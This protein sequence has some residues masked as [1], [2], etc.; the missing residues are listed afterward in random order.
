MID[1]V[2]KLNAGK[3]RRS[4]RRSKKR[5]RIS[6]RAAHLS[7]NLPLR[8]FLILTRCIS[9]MKDFISRQLRFRVSGV[10]A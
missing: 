1:Y 7:R 8:L 3:E 2:P 10:A 5:V 6:P 9:H 4:A